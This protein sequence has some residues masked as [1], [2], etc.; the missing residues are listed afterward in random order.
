[1][2]TTCCVLST[3][4]LLLTV[5]AAD[6]SA[7]FVPDLLGVWEG[8]IRSRTEASLD[9][10][11]TRQARLPTRRLDEYWR[12]DFRRT[13]VGIEGWQR[14]VPHDDMR[15][16]DDAVPFGYPHRV[17][18][19]N[20]PEFEMEWGQGTDY[21]C[22]AD[23]ELRDGGTEDAKIEGR[24]VCRRRSNDRAIIEWVTRGRIELTPYRPGEG[25]GSGTSPLG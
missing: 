4:I 15:R 16:M 21:R 11:N 3:S 17:T 13:A 1:M 6:L 12:I 19:M 18:E 22:E 14:Y 5:G 10:A 20:P 2:R 8:R 24:Y 23:L 9:P 25:G 7:Q